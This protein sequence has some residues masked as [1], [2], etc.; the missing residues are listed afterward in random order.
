MSFGSADVV[1]SCVPITQDCS[2]MVIS[3][4]ANPIMLFKRFMRLSLLI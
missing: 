2:D 1:F 3:S 4:I